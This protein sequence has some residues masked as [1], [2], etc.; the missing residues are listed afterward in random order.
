MEFKEVTRLPILF[1]PPQIVTCSSASGG[2]CP[3]VIECHSYVTCAENLL[4]SSTYLQPIFNLLGVVM[5]HFKS[6]LLAFGKV[7]DAF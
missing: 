5:E 2:G 1:R 4:F 6:L 7:C 3:R